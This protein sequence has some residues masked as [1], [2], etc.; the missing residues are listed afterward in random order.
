[1]AVSRRH[2][3]VPDNERHRAVRLPSTNWRTNGSIELRTSSGVP[4]AM[5][6]PADTK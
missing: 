2:T 5:I 3:A 1:M 4:C 6:R